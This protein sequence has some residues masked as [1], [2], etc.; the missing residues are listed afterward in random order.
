MPTEDH[1]PQHTAYRW[2]WKMVRR[3]MHME[4]PVLRGIGGIRPISIAALARLVVCEAIRIGTRR[5]GPT[6]II[7]G[8]RLLPLWMIILVGLL[9]RLQNQLLMMPTVS[10]NL[11]VGFSRSEQGPH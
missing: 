3:T 7:G 10:R 5:R 11:A 4:R 1:M 9:H 2:L 8:H 6:V